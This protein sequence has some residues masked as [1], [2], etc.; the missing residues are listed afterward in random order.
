MRLRKKKEPVVV[1]KGECNGCGYCCRVIGRV[2]L[3]WPEQV[4]DPA[5]LDV[6][7]IER[8][9]TKWID[10]VDPCPK[11]EELPSEGTSCTI[12]ANRPQTC[13]AFPT[14]PADVEGTPCSYWFEDEEGKVIAHGEGFPGK[15]EA[16]QGGIN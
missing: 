1:R 13:Q 7:G 4:N 2:Q 9:G 11:L 12:W 3:Q 8:D 6:R 15:E 10:V 16:D 5:F 14:R